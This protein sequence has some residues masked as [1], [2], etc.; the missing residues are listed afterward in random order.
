VTCSD[1]TTG[2]G[3]ACVTA[4]LADGSSSTSCTD[5]TSGDGTA[6]GGP[7]SGPGD[8]SSLPIVDDD[9]HP[10]DRPVP[11]ILAIADC[12]LAKGNVVGEAIDNAGYI[13]WRARQLLN[14]VAS[15]P[16]EALAAQRW[17]TYFT[18][19]QNFGSSPQNWFGDYSHDKTAK[20]LGAYDDIW[21]KYLRP[22]ASGYEVSC[23]CADGFPGSAHHWDAS[24]PK[25]CDGFFA[26]YNS[27]LERGAI[28]V[29]EFLHRT[30]VDGLLIGDT[31]YGHDCELSYGLPKCY[32]RPDA[33]K[34]PQED[35]VDAIHNN[36]NYEYF[37]LDLADR[38][39]DGNC[40][41]F[42]VCS[43]RDTSNPACQ[44]VVE[45]PP[46]YPECKDPTDP[47]YFGLPGCPCADVQV[48]PFDV[49]S[50]AEDGGY[51]DGAG[52]YLHAAGAGAGAP[53]QYC[54][55]VGAVCDTLTHHGK[56]YP[57]CRSCDDQAEIGCPCDSQSDCASGDGLSCYG[58]ADQGYAPIGSGTCLP[59]GSSVASR[60]K[61]TDM[62]W[63]CLDNCAALNGYGQNGVSA[64]AYDQLPGFQFDHGTCVNITASCDVLPGMCE[65]Q[66]RICGFVGPNDTDQ[67]QAE[68]E[69]DLDCGDRGFPDWYACDAFGAPDRHCV[70]PECA[71]SSSEYCGLFR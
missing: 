13:V 10:C 19:Y 58:S 44:P 15:A 38:Y 54:A 63:F 5:L 32:S 42:S 49:E 67:C 61:L 21:D 4:T 14:R 45:D 33:L 39:L 70:P 16:S 48:N 7:P 69:D 53:G 25:V 27:P 26:A 30:W 31:H 36:S 47:S 3:T 37:G 50:A 35:P 1:L 60:E 2:T 57:I 51:S 68:C 11:G 40:G 41:N 12:S 22:G 46:S 24:G 52:S 59:D 23:D 29:H 8:L 55:G 64:C 34:L 20:I 6:G 66:G 17:E 71:N 28:L 56:Q 62:P 9:L 43:A 18:T 65:E